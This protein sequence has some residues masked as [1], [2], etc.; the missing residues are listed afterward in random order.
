D[1]RDILHE[2]GI[3]TDYFRPMGSAEGTMSVFARRLKNGRRRC[4]DWLD[5]FIDV[6]VAFKDNLEM[7]TL[8]VK[9]E[10][11]QESQKKNL[12]KKSPKQFVEKLKDS[13]AET[14]RGNVA[15]LN[16]AVGKTVTDA[17]KGLRG[18]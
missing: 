1:Y 5:S 12:E 11:S 8:Q 18:F 3:K 16:Q 2:R 7:K 17:L 9:L 4:R 15:Y 14:T 13:V 6:M 10:Q